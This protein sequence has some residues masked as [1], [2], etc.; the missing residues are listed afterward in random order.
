MQFISFFIKLVTNNILEEFQAW[1]NDYKYVLRNY[2]K[3]VKVKQEL[4]YAHLEDY[5]YSGE[6][7][8][9]VTLID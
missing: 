5:V 7:A 3:K 9:E 6:N 4:F 2:R 1:F 8:C